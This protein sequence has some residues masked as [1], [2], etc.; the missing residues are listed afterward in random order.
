MAFKQYSY[1]TTQSN[2]EGIDW[3]TDNVYAQLLNITHTYSTAHDTRNNVVSAVVGSP[4]QLTAKTKTIS[5]LSTFLSCSQVQFTGT[6]SA[7][8]VVFMVGSAASVNLADK[9]LAIVDLNDGVAAE[10]TVNFGIGFNGGLF[11]LRKGV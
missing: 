7:K 6:P 1:A 10:V 5:G 9:L 4:I 2:L 3:V 8:Y 11:T